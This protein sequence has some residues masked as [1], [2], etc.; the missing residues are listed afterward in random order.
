MEIVV[1][2]VVDLPLLTSFEGVEYK[3]ILTVTDRFTK[4]YYLILAKSIT[5]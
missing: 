1:N 4:E 2:F 5:V 3:N